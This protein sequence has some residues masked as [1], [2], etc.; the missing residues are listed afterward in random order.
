LS[1]GDDAAAMAGALEAAAERVTTDRSRAAFY[2]L[3]A[4]TYAR[5]AGDAPG[6]RA[7]LSQAGLSGA[8]P[9]LVARVGRLLSSAIGDAP[10]YEEST[11]RLIG[12]GAHAD[13]QAS[14]WFELGRAR[15]I[16]GE[17][18]G[19]EA[20]FQAIAEAPGG[21]FLG[22]TLLAFV[23]ELLP[24]NDGDTAA[25][26]SKPW[27]PLV[28]LARE[29]TSAE[30]AR[31]ERTAAALRAL[32]K[33]ENDVA[34]E[35]LSSLHDDD[36]S[37]AVVGVALG[38]LETLRGRP[39]D[40]ARVLSATAAATTDSELGVALRLEAGLLDWRAGER[41]SA[42]RAFEQ[43]AETSEAAA[44][45]MAAWALRVADPNDP[46]ARRRAL[47][48]SEATDG[49]ASALERFTLEVGPGGQ[50]PAARAALGRAVMPP[51]GGPG[52]GLV[53]ALALW[54]GTD[55]TQRAAALDTLAEQSPEAA[56]LARA[57]AF[58][59]ELSHA[60][61]ASPD[62]AEAEA[63]AARWAEAEGSTAAALEWLAAA[64]A[65]ADVPAEV[66][67][68]RLLASRLG[69][70]SGEPIAASAGNRRLAHGHR[71]ATAARRRE[72]SHPARERG[73]RAARHRSTP[74]RRSAL[75]SRRPLRRRVARRDAGPRRIQPAR[76]R[77]RQVGAHDLP[78]R[79]R[80]SS[81]RDHR[82]GR[83]QGRRGARRGP[84]GLGR[85]LRGA[86]RPRERRRSR[87]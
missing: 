58:E 7:A 72:R 70:A 14:L 69:G 28:A 20:A 12:H 80:S 39:T 60:N 36:P 43:A 59:L 71:R 75:S 77:R 10:W 45:A 37:D 65:K 51:A 44:G 73:N 64:T 23:L 67:A 34:R 54:E 31:A 86:R 2:L 50:E 13:E 8:S 85:G 40:G 74:P 53:M 38:T 29:E 46:D 9:A 24:E 47:E 22:Q 83:S 63:L 78:R 4:D 32:R 1:T 57:A 27:E 87:G 5:A 25:Q 68:R 82:L 41:K 19:A 21:T 76:V 62:A 66:A 18:S 15:A 16:R 48:A 61:G 33:G 42:L 30:V 6:A 79:G 81:A 17:R 3:A 35:L 55:R 84:P 26:G 52:L 56:V 49:M 11:R